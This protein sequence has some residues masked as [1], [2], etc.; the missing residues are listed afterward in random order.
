[1]TPEFWFVL[2]TK[3]IQILEGSVDPNQPVDPAITEELKRAK[4]LND[5]HIAISKMRKEV[6]T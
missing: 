6:T 3:L 5:V 4:D 2:I 1:M